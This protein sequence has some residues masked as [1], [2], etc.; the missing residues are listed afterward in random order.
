MFV[1]LIMFSTSTVG[2]RLR[3]LP[4][5]WQLFG[6]CFKRPYSEFT[7]IQE[8]ILGKSLSLFAQF[9]CLL[10]EYKVGPPFLFVCSLFLYFLHNF[11]E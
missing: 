7:C 6:E 4:A 1:V 3:Q 10:A 9:D 8:P 2:S 11:F 5:V